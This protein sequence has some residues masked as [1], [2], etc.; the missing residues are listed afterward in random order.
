M[1]RFRSS[2]SLRCHFWRELNWISDPGRDLIFRNLCWMTNLLHFDSLDFYLWFAIWS[3]P[4]Q[5]FGPCTSTPDYYGS[6]VISVFARDK[7]QVERVLSGCLLLHYTWGQIRDATNSSVGHTDRE[8]SVQL[9]AQSYVPSSLLLPAFIFP[10]PHCCYSL[11]T[12]VD[13]CSTVS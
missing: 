12:T 11:L 13:I 4:T 9:R 3:V 5:D 10:L 2:I 8:T 1:Y 7:E 6:L